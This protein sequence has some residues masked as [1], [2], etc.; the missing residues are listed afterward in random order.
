MREVVLV[1]HFHREELLHC[2]LKRLRGYDGDIPIHVFPDR[3]TYHDSTVRATCTT[4]EAK[5][6]LVLDNDF[7]GNTCNVMNAYLWAYNEGYDRVYMVE[8]DVMIHS[9][10]FSWHREQ[11]EENLDIFAS[12][13]WIF[14]REAPITNDIL[15]QPWIYSIGLCFSREKL[16]LVVEHATPKY[17]GD[18]PG[19]ISRRFKADSMNGSFVVAHYEQDGLLQAILNEDRSQTVAPGIA[20]CSHIGAVRSYGDGTQR[21]YEEFF[22]F[23]QLGFT[24]RVKRIEEFIADPYWRVQA[25]G[26]ALVER[27]VGYELPKREFKYHITLPGGWESTFKSELSK[28]FLPRRINSVPIPADAQIVVE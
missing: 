9:D 22:G 5:P 2:C 24:D 4:F 19:Y 1:P 23:G 28:S 20:K 8:S 26:R 13:A 15:F 10:F 14:N 18:M 12:M 25:F 27:E 16:R 3:G 7:Y 21:G 11:Q 6:H 17:Y